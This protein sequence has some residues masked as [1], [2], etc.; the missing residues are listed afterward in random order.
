MDGAY[1]FQPE[2][3]V[4]RDEFVVLAM[5]AAGHKALDGVAVTGFAD[6]ASIPAWAKGYVSSALMSGMV[7]GAADENGAISFCT[8]A[9]ITRAEAAAVL[10]RL[11]RPEDVD[12]SVSA[13]AAE[14]V[15]AWASQAAA[16]LESLSIPTAAPLTE[17]LTRG[18]AAQLLCA[19]LEYQD[20]QKTGWF[21]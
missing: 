4:S 19:F 12:V 7:R 9:D 20:S 18:E 2:L 17:P 21:A 16:N 14:S 6:D 13:F 11:L 10:N 15:P 8:G 1:Y 3:T 5:S